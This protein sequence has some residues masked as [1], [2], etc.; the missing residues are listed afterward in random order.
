[1]AEYV[2]KCVP[3]AMAHIDRLRARA[4]QL[5]SPRGTIP[6]S[7]CL[8]SASWRMAKRKRWS[9][10]VPIWELRTN[11]NTDDQAA[12]LMAGCSR[13][14]ICHRLE[15]LCIVACEAFMM[16]AQKDTSRQTKNRIFEKPAPCIEGK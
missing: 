5:W 6:E 7:K 13:R 12:E 11:L 3:E 1:M 10:P 8:M 9:L 4:E 2:Q 16:C 14:M 15:K